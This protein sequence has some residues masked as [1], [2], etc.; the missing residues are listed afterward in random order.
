MQTR[1]VTFTH[2]F[3]YLLGNV[4]NNFGVQKWGYRSPPPVRDLHS[5]TPERFSTRVSCVTT[6]PN[7]LQKW[8]PQT[9]TMW[10]KTIVSNNG[11]VL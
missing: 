5:P 8:M 3:W 9:R 2:K 11:L 6:M 1:W 4:D 7:A 10:P